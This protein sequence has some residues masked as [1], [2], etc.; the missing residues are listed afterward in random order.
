MTSLAAYYVFVATTA[1]RQA[2]EEAARRDPR[3]SFFGRLRFAVA[4]FLTS[5][6][7]APRPA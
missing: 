7:Q 2:S 6:S 4:G 3:R 5:R 1:S